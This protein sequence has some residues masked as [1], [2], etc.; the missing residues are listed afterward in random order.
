MGTNYYFLTKK[1]DLAKKYFQD[2]YEL[3]D[4][5]DF[6]Y[7]IHL[8]KLSCGWK[9]LFENHK[10]FDTFAGLEKFYYDHK[11]DLEI[12]DEYG[13][14]YTFEDY[15]NEVIEHSQVEPTPVKWVYDDK[16]ISTFGILLH[17]VDCEPEEAD[18]WTPFDHIEYTQTEKETRDKLGVYSSWVTCVDENMY[19]NDPDYNFDWSEGR[20]V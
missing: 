2:E 13:T 5:P 9:P 18:L 4:E 15:K 10:A 3:I 8:N 7:E 11:D 17:T 16:D 14:F 1:K 20:F 12:Q 6:Y 19:H